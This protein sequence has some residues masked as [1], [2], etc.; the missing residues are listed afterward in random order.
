MI[1]L[2]CKKHGKVMVASNADTCCPL[3]LREVK[4]RRAPDWADVA[5]KT[6]NVV[7]LVGERGP[8]SEPKVYPAPKI[9]IRIGRLGFRTKRDRDVRAYR[10][11]WWQFWMRDKDY[12]A[13]DEFINDF[14]GQIEQ[15]STLA[16]AYRFFEEGGTELHAVRVMPKE[17]GRDGLE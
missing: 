17:E 12:C 7:P 8:V 15:T 6:F 5:K 11:L 10:H 4:F 2:D 14:G 16:E 1:E 3:C 9:R 13:M